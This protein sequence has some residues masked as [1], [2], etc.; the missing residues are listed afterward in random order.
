M[1]PQEPHPQQSPDEG[2]VIPRLD[3]AVFVDFG[4]KVGERDVQ[5]SPGRKSDGAT[6]PDRVFRAD[7]KVS[8]GGTERDRQ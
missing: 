5:E 7:E 6:D 1:I 4:Q 2:E 8:Q 3:V